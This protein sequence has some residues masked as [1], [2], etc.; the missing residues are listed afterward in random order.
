MFNWLEFLWQKTD[1]KNP[2]FDFI[3][4]KNDGYV[5]E[6]FRDG[7]WKT[8]LKTRCWQEAS[9]TAITENKTGNIITIDFWENGTK[10]L[11][12]IPFDLHELVL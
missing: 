7:K 5:V 2:I 1:I 3:K 9:N 11:S 8:I 12:D 4:E 10:R 6:S